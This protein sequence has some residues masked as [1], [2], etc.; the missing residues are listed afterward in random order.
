MTVAA[1]QIADCFLSKVLGRGEATALSAA[2]SAACLSGLVTAALPAASVATGPPATLSSE[3]AAIGPGV[4]P[5]ALPVGLTFRADAEL[6]AMLAR[7]FEEP[8]EAVFVEEKEGGV[9][10]AGLSVDEVPAVPDEEEGGVTLPA[11][12][13]EEE[14][15]AAAPADPDEEEPAD[16][17]V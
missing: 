16:V 15:R 5:C 1:A 2:L 17:S 8:L 13:T 14:E 9:V 12:L 7:L 10:V 6:P 11:G 4:E 3:A